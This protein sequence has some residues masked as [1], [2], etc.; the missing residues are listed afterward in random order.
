MRP[1]RALKEPKM[2][3]EDTLR[4]QGSATCLQD[5]SCWNSPVRHL[6]GLLFPPVALQAQTTTKATTLSAWTEC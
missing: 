5:R 3:D 2:N 1:G 4:Y 6:M